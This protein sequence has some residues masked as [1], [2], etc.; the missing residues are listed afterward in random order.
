MF[1]NQIFILDRVSCEGCGLFIC[2][3][4]QRFCASCGS[5][6]TSDIEVQATDLDLEVELAA[7][8]AD[9]QLRKSGAV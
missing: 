7:M 4:G 8:W 9:E 6:A 2:E 5:D 3:P 1:K